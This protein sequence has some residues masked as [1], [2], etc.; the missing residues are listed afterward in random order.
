MKLRIIR[1]ERAAAG[2]FECEVAP[3]GSRY[4]VKL[5][6]RLAK[7]PPGIRLVE[8]CRTVTEAHR[9]RDQWNEIDRMEARRLW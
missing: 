3:P 8:K 7:F 5:F 4:S 1:T 2:V 6:T 9:K